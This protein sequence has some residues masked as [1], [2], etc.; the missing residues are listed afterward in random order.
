MGAGNSTRQ[1]ES[2]IFQYVDAD[3]L[4][5]EVVQQLQQLSAAQ[6]KQLQK[7]L[8]EQHAQFI[9]QTT[10]IVQNAVQQNKQKPAP[11]HV[12]EL[13]QVQQEA[14]ENVDNP[15]VKHQ[16]E[17]KI[18][19][20]AQQHQRTV[21]HLINKALK[22]ETPKPEMKKKKSGRAA[23]PVSPTTTE[24]CKQWAANKKESR[25]KPINPWSNHP[26]KYRKGTYKELN[27]M[28]KSKRKV[29]T[30][31]ST[32]IYNGKPYAPGSTKGKFVKTFCN[33]GSEK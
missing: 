25:A 17:A 9:H 30:D 20:V 22:K 4:P 5:D 10:S 29:C 32:S 2:K 7:Q 15:V 21:Q 14:L 3:E 8:R 6:K 19:H 27:K 16:A 24:K 28:C 23:A 18:S 12:Y 26:V 13:P 1:Q 31:P 11:A 33:P